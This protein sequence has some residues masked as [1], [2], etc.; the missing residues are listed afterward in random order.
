[1][2]PGSDS[3]AP[4]EVAVTDLAVNTADLDAAAA[5]LRKVAA[6][7]AESTNRG[8]RLAALVPALGSDRAA[9]AAS[10]FLSCWVYGTGWVRAQSED[11][12]PGCC[13]N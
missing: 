10:E 8:G 3:V 12:S 7:C 4:G 2:L 6:V 1:M 11:L 9:Q 13:A 5:R